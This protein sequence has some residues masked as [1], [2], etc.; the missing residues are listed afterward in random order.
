MVP[1]H[2]AYLL[3]LRCLYGLHSSRC[4]DGEEEESPTAATIASARNGRTS[5]RSCG[6]STCHGACDETGR[7]SN[8]DAPLRAASLSNHG[9]S[10]GH[11][12]NCDLNGCAPILST[13]TEP[14]NDG[15][16]SGS[17]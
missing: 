9:S 10:Y 17:D 4:G 2:V 1:P 6:N 5:F 3:C 13:R 11:G 8:S 16:R 7:G 12:A 14:R 15:S